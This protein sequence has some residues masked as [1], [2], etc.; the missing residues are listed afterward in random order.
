MT[1]EQGFLSSAI[2]EWI[3]EAKKKHKSWF[4]YVSEA[5]R[6]SM[7]INDSVIPDPRNNKQLLGKLLYLR[8]LQSFQGAILL[9]ERGMITEARTLVRSCAESAIALGGAAS[10]DDFPEQL[11]SAH[12]K[13]RRS[14]ASYLNTYQG[15]TEDQRSVVDETTSSLNGKS[16]SPINWEYVAKKSGMELMYNGV[17]R[18]LSGDSA[19]VTM[20]ALDRLLKDEGKKIHFGPTDDDL[21][22]TLSR[23]ICSLLGALLQLHTIYSG[24]GIEARL[25][26][27][28]EKWGKLVE[29]ER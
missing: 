20:L 18:A 27:L 15:L 17:Y 8:T 1:T 21:P 25:Q 4:D 26:P 3:E 13:H 24:C 12:D 28:V 7:A 22:D 19:H 2:A 11:Q 23:A 6:E 16:L 10:I 9:A 14:L 29:C 5:N